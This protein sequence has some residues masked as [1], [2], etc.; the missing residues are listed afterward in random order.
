MYFSKI[1][2]A[3]AFLA[4]VSPVA[5]LANAPQTPAAIESA[6]LNTLSQSDRAQVQNVLGLLSVGQV[7]AETAVSQIDAV[8]SDSEA[9]SVLAYAKQANSDTQDAGQ[10]LVDLAR[11]SS[12]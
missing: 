9:K 2:L 12:K 6:A 7:D 8:L 11:P 10:F 1:F 5:A 3:G 4:L